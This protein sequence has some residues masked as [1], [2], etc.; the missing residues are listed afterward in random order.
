M[1]KS[2]NRS[3]FAIVIIIVLV[4]VGLIGIGSY[5]LVKKLQEH[6]NIKSKDQSSIQSYRACGCGCCGGET[7]GKEVCLHHSNGDDINTIINDD[8][9]ARLNPQCYTM[10]CSA[11][12]T[13]KYCD[14]NVATTTV[15]PSSTA[16]AD[17]YD[18]KTYRNE[19]FGFSL[20]YDTV[21]QREKPDIIID[22]ASILSYDPA[23]D[24]EFTVY[25]YRDL[26]KFHSQNY[27][28]SVDNYDDITYS[29]TKKEWIVKSTSGDSLC[30]IEIIGDQGVP[31]YRITTGHHAGAH[32][33]VYVTDKGI[34]VFAGAVYRD[35][36]GIFQDDTITFNNPKSVHKASCLVAR[37]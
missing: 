5:V 16:T 29:P 3:G 34:V 2:Q 37:Q 14:Q 10:G 26:T 35:S 22:S 33:R 17:N 7:F 24:F 27:N 36:K 6:Q 8:K 25:L 30:P 20:T 19:V 4:F 32:I 13:Y 1:Q 11:G 15:S 18:W 21:S 31:Y 28:F 23:A 9:K 12:I